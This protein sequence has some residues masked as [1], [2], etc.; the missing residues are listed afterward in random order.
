MVNVFAQVTGSFIGEDVRKSAISAMLEKFGSDEKFRIEKGVRQTA[1]FW[2]SGDGSADDF[3]KFCTGNFA[4]SGDELESLFKR[5]EFF[6]ESLFGYYT[7][8]GIKL[9]MPLDLEMGDIKPVDLIM[10]GYNPSA[11]LTDD[12]FKNKYAFVILLNF[13][14]FSLDEKTALGSKWSRLEWAYARLASTFNARVPADI[15]QKVNGAYTDGDNY[16]SNYNIY[17]GNLV[18]DDF[19]SLFPKELKLITHWGLRDELKGRY[20]NPGDL[21]KQEMIYMIMQ[22]IIR[23]EIPKKVINNNEY[24]WNPFSNKIF[25][26]GI[27][28]KGA[29]REVDKRYFMLLNNFKANKLLDDYY[30]DLNT[31]IKRSF[32]LGREVSEKEVEDMFVE[33]LSSPVVKKVADVVKSKLGRELRPFDIWF[34]GFKSKSKINESELDNI[35]KAKYPDVEAFENDIE[36]ILL[37]LGFAQNIADFVSG[38]ITVDNSRGAGHAI[39]AAIREFKAR[40]RTRI[41]KDGMTYKGYNI[42]VHELGHNVEQ[43]LT[44]YNIDPYSLNGV[45]NT[46]FTEAFAFV[47]QARDLELLG[48]E[49]PAPEAEDL[50]ALDIFWSTFEIMGVSLVDMKVW[51]WMYENPDCTPAELKDAVIRIAKEVWNKYYAPVFGENDVILLAVY[52]HMIDNPLYLPNY[53]L[54]H[55]IQ[56]QIEDYLKNKTV[57][58]EMMRMCANGNIVPQVWMRNSVGTDISVLPL[59]SA[60]E[61][62]LANLGY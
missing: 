47:F 36:N 8:M 45:P 52:S 1:D 40:L 5:I 32:E 17:M 53:A 13:P 2:N 44:L 48:L 27:E 15:N 3:L 51:N 24:Q 55:L 56:F 61:K 50:K 7:E 25:K 26:N 59:L 46:S 34:T 42:A 16:I 35:V 57:G 49:N 62:A 38:K 43:T 39:G 19:V 10:G 28:E 18:D 21:D 4:R 12:L 60:V 33:M 29:A 41:G 54:G 30:P 14:K 37:K 58:P 6:N 20:A 23:Q 31:H 9:R 11:H 22:R